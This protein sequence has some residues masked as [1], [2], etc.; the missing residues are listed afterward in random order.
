L[1]AAANCFSSVGEGG[2]RR[3][4]RGLEIL[5]RDRIA[6]V[7]EDAHRQFRW[8]NPT[9]RRASLGQRATKPATSRPTACAQII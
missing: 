8:L 9:W 7:L 1:S 3:R 4:V 5:R 2:L 6:V